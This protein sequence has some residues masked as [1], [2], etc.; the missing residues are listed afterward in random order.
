MKTSPLRH[1]LPALAAFALLYLT[2]CE[3]PSNV[4]LGLVGEQGGEPITT[5]EAIS[6]LRPDSLERPASVPPRVLTGIVDDP[7]IGTIAAEGYVDFTPVSSSD[8]RGGTIQSAELRLLPTYLYG[9]TTQEI[10]LAIRPVSEEWSPTDLPVDTTFEVGALIREFTFQPTDSIV[11]V[12][13]PATWVSSNDELLRSE[14]FAEDFHGFRIDHVGG[15]AVVGFGPNSTVL[16]SFTEEDSASYP[17]G[18][19][20]SALSKD[21]AAPPN[22]RVLVQAGIGPEAKFNFELE[23]DDQVGA[24]NRIALAFR[25]DTLTLEQNLPVGFV[26]PSIRTLD[27]YGITAEGA[28]V[29]LARGNLGDDGRFVFQS[30]VL[31]REIQSTL[32]GDR[33][34]ESFELRI[35]APVTV[36]DEQTVTERLSASISAVLLYGTGTGDEAPT[37]YLTITPIDG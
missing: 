6:N 34:Y 20:Y 22:N 35:P 5:Q 10:T 12:S 18:K 28:L 23:E 32:L 3:D 36:S 11:V 31:A 17:I 21:E 9:D 24:I 29:L 37:A 25:A 19:A 4:G 16:R 13:M 2:A 15:N 27:L 30:D 1:S 8:F 7:L 14:N 33:I 26:R